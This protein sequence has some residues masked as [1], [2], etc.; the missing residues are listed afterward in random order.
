[1]FVG[2]QGVRE[3][4]GCLLCSRCLHVGKTEG[5]VGMCALLGVICCFLLWQVFSY[6]PTFV[7]CFLVQNEVLGLVFCAQ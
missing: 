3:V 5:G 2:T 6:S 7:F 1:M 4:E